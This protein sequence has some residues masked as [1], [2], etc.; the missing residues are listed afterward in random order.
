MYLTHVLLSRTLTEVGRLYGRDR[1]TVAHACNAV[2]DRRDDP[3][4]EAE[5]EAIESRLAAEPDVAEELRHAG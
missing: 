5:I 3:A 1:T 4:L 2:E